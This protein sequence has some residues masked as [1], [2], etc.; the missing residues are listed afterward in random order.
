[1]ENVAMSRLLCHCMVV[2]EREVVRAIRQG[3]RTVEAVGEACEAGTGCGS[4]RGGIEVVLQQESLRR[5]R[6]PVPD[7]VAAQLGLFAAKDQ[8]EA[9]P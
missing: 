3:A 4:C 1:M 9:G 7:A 5:S 6:R 8:S 2:D